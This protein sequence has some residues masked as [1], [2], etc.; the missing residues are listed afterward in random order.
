MMKQKL[1]HDPVIV[2]NMM[3]YTKQFFMGYSIVV[4]MVTFPLYKTACYGMQ[5]FC[6]HSYSCITQNSLLWDVVSLSPWLQP[7]Y[8]NSLLLDEVFL[9]P[10]LQLHYTK[11]LIMGCSIFVAMVTAALQKQLVIGCSI[12]VAM[13]TAA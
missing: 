11:Q 13:V 10:W 2:T 4:A 6:R 9:S 8:K 3:H 7:H 1:L 5:Y 12:F